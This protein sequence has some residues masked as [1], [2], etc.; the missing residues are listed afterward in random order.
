MEDQTGDGTTHGIRGPRG[1]LHVPN[2]RQDCWRGRPDGCCW[3]CY[4]RLLTT[5]LG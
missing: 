4:G 1:R 3:L 2:W 5:A